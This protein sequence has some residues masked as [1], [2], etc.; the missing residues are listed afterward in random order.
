[1]AN[2]NPAHHEPAATRQ[3]GSELM[4]AGGE[5]E[6]T[7]LFNRQ[8]VQNHST[9]GDPTQQSVVPSR[10]RVLQSGAGVNQTANGTGSGSPHKEG[11]APSGDD[12]NNNN[13]NNNDTKHITLEQKRNIVE[14]LATLPYK[15]IAK[16]IAIMTT[17]V[18]EKCEL[19]FRQFR[20]M[21]HPDKW[22][23]D[24]EAAKWATDAHN[25]L[26]AFKDHISRTHGPRANINEW[27]FYHSDE[28]EVYLPEPDQA[29]P[30]LYHLQAYQE[31]TRYL[32]DLNKEIQ[33]D[34]S[35]KGHKRK[36]LE[37]CL[38]RIMLG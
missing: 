10:A 22:S 16:S 20:L 13:N 38:E 25:N 19:R 17:T 8:L 11:Y 5:D 28:G 31:A 23:A 7:S 3:D 30:R 14:K 33:R 4:G 24:H 18:P 29:P 1:M 26:E 34:L 2:T 9:A 32:I 15:D 37:D 27:K 36:E 35:G 12:D 21:I 6:P